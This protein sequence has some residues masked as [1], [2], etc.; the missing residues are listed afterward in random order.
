MFR[1]TASGG[2]RPRRFNAKDVVLSITPIL[3]EDDK[4]K[5]P[6]EEQPADQ[7][8]EALKPAPDAD[9]NPEAEGLVRG[10]TLVVCPMSLLAQWYVLS[11]MGWSAATLHVYGMPKTGSS[12]DL[13]SA[14]D[15]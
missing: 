1:S 10:G 5:A 2:V 13:T 11:S 6:M 3:D 7:S 4:G 12:Y 8:D 14:K 15:S 9:P